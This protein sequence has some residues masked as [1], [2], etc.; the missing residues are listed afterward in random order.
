M[1]VHYMS[2]PIP[3]ITITLLIVRLGIYIVNRNAKKEKEE[4]E[5]RSYYS[6]YESQKAETPPVEKSEVGEQ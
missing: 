4:E 3:F 6:Q 5:E 1:H 2:Y